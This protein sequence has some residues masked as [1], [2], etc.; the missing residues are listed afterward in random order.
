MAGLEESSWSSEA[1]DDALELRVDGAYAVLSGCY[2]L[3]SKLAFGARVWRSSNKLQ[4][5]PGVFGW[6]YRDSRG[7]WQ[8]TDGGEEESAALGLERGLLAGN[9]L[10]LPSPALE[11]GWSCIEGGRFVRCDATCTVAPTHP[12]H[13]DDL[14]VGGGLPPPGTIK[15]LARSA[16]QVVD[17]V[18]PEVVH[19]A[20]LAAFKDFASAQDVGKGFFPGML[21]GEDPT[22]Q[23]HPPA[24]WST[25]RL[26]EARIAECREY[27]ASSLGRG[28]LALVPAVSAET[29][30]TSG[31]PSPLRWWPPSLGPA[32][33]KASAGSAAA[34]L[35][36]RTERYLLVT[37]GDGDCLLHSL[38]LGMWGMHARL[39][40]PAKHAAA[41]G[42]GA[43]EGSG[44]NSGGESGSEGLC[45]QTEPLRMLLGQMLGAEA[46]KASTVPRFDRE[47]RLGNAS[48]P[49][50]SRLDS[51]AD[52][53]G[54]TRHVALEWESAINEATQVNCFLGPL[55]VYALAQVL[56]RPL[57]VYEAGGGEEAARLSGGEFMAGVY[58]PFLWVDHGHYES[59][60]REPL[61]LL[62]TH[63]AG[64]GQGH[65]TAVVASA[66]GSGD[67]G[68]PPLVPLAWAG[69]AGEGG[70]PHR[71]GLLPVRFSLD[72]DDP[73]GLLRSCLD[74]EYWPETQG[75]EPWPLARGALDPYI[76]PE[77]AALRDQHLKLQSFRAADGAR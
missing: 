31:A 64:H 55:H 70:D 71:R 63:G 14:F 19:S 76:L 77:A 32:D 42:G 40:T 49:E 44:G 73:L 62:F 2:L 3:T 28:G 10:R 45:L 21:P 4:E 24:S 33:P 43:S 69:S 39:R 53:E 25:Y 26:P 47:L 52:F 54:W 37:E 74:L 68:G 48:L 41:A 59:V 6:L 50:E 60:S 18:T 51:E 17:S 38:S 58:L 36:A 65:F 29:G 9:G 75:A 23:G 35:T 13:A 1:D 5:L 12:A 57:V 11:I 72:G 15:G 67:S 20:R 66:L 8:V 56:R 16:T 61:T 27:A 34:S 22:G 7:V 46:F 30:E